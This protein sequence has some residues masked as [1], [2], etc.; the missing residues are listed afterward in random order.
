MF[1][2]FFQFLL[3]DFKHLA[4]LHLK[5]DM[6]FFPAIVKIKVQG[7]RRMTFLGKP[8]WLGQ[9]FSDAMPALMF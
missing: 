8:S 4:M 7:K 5:L 3:C 1:V 6:T 9:F 2:T